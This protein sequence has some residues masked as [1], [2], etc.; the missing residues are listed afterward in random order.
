MV[1]VK[2]NLAAALLAASPLMAVAEELSLELST[3]RAAD[4]VTEDEMRE[5]SASLTPLLEGLPGFVSRQVSI[6]EDGTWTDAVVWTSLDAAL[7]A[8]EAFAAFPEGATFFEMVD[9]DAVTLQHSTII[10]G[11]VL[12][13]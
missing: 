4:G 9:P 2:K 10:E 13:N 5:V 3:Y 6:A 8:A 12:S 1:G 11:S 7:P